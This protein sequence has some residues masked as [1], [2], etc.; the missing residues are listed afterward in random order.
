[1]TQP[2]VLSRAECREFDRRAVEEFGMPSLLLM[3][4]A[5]RGCV[6]VLCSLLA[7]REETARR[8][9]AAEHLAERDDYKRRVVVLCGK[10]NNGG[11][12]FVIARRLD[13][14]G[15]KVLVVLCGR[16]D[17]L[18]GDAAAMW[19]ILARCEIETT[20][21][22]PSE[23]DL[24]RKLDALLAD[25]DWIVDGLLGTGATGEPRS[26]IADAIDA[27]NRS[28]AKKLAVDLPSGLDCDTGLPAKHTVRADHTC[29]FVALKP[30]FLVPSAP[31][32]LGQVHIVDIG[33]P[34][35]LADSVGAAQSAE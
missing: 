2:L 32:Y 16:P 22:A 34:R 13:L 10:G 8:S 6:D 27:I 24:A 30:G 4:N 19:A 35:K 11:D 29:T 28:P 23:V 15:Y 18:R 20:M 12:G 31:P 21:I 3:E 17:E 7:P 5:G 25:A 1:M 9:R 26:P 14:L 33:C